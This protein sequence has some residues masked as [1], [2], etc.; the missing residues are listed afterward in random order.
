MRPLSQVNAASDTLDSTDLKA[1]LDSVYFP[2]HG[3]L[4]LEKVFLSFNFTSTFPLFYLRRNHVLA[5][6]ETSL[7]S[8][9]YLLPAN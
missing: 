1:L 5:A 7:F 4:R 2:F 6:V 9:L 3:L 8:Y